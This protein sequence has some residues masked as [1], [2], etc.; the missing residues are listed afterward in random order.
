MPRVGEVEGVSYFFVSPSTFSS[1]LSQDAFIEYTI[2]SGNYYGTSK[3]TIA[4]QTAKGSIVVLDIEMEGVMSMKSSGIDARYVF[5]KPPS[6][7][8]LEARLRNRRTEKEEDIP[9]RLARAKLELEFA[10]TPGV[11]DLVIVNDDLEKAVRELEEFVFGQ[12]SK[13]DKPVC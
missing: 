13:Y 6:F 1:L 10:D 5:V 4:D 8:T 12:P 3:Q 2:F 7:D 11:H 9:K